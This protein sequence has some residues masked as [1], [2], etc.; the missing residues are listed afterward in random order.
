M[1]AVS[2][3]VARWTS[4]PFLDIRDEP[5]VIIRRLDNGLLDVLVTLPVPNRP[6]F[7]L[8]FV[9]RVGEPEGEGSPEEGFTMQWWGLSRL[10]PSVWLVT[11]SVVTPELHAFIVIRDVPEPAPFDVGAGGG[12]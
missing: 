10:G 5:V 8:S 2:L 11:P 9:A 1:P 7:P 4:A 3:L 6:R 12:I